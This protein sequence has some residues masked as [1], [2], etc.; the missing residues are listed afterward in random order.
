MLAVNFTFYVSLREA[1]VLIEEAASVVG[2]PI[3]ADSYNGN[4][5]CMDMTH[6]T[7]ATLSQLNTWSERD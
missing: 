6:P 2:A 1:S 4:G 3:V 5:P 7:A